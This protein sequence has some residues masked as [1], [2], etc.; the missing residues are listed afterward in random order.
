MMLTS[1]AFLL[2]IVVLQ[3]CEVLPAPAWG[4]LLLLFVPLSIAFRALRLPLLIFCGFL[5]ALLQAH[6]QLYPELSQQW[7]GNDLMVEGVIASIPQNRGRA[8]RFL[9]D[10]DRVSHA[11]GRQDEFPRRIRLSWYG[12]T[13]I[14]HLAQRWKFTVRLKRPRGFKNPG[15]FDY[16]R[17][18]FAQGIRATG[19]VRGGEGAVLLTDR[20]SSRPVDLLRR[21]LADHITQALG[22]ESNRGV[23]TALTIGDRSAM[24]PQ[25]WRLLL[26]TGTNHLLAISGLHIGLVAGLIYFLVLRMWSLAGQLCLKWP[27]PRIAAIAAIGAGC[28]YAMLAGF[29]VPT[30]RAA[31]MLCV[32]MGAVLLNRTKRAVHTLALA[33]MVVLIW[34]SLAVLSA[35]FWLSFAAVAL[36]FY[37]IVDRLSEQRLWWRWGRV[38]WVLAIGLFPLTLILFQRV[39]LVAPI[40]N[41]FAVPW[42]GMLIVPLTLMGSLLATVSTVAGEF[43]LGVASALLDVFWVGLD[44]LADFPMAQ[45]HHLP[46]LWALMPAIPGLILLLAP[47]GWPGRW[48][49]LVLFSPLVLTSP[50]KPAPGDYWV[51]LLDVGQGLSMVI[52]T[53]NHTLVYDAGAR[54]SE[55]FNAGEAVVA[56][57]LRARGVRT[58]DLLVISHG[59]N[60]HIGGADAIMH[61]LKVARV[62]TSVPEQLEH[63]SIDICVAGMRW[64]WDGVD[65]EVLHP[66]EQWQGSKNDQSCVLFLQGAGGSMLITG[67]IESKAEQRLTT[68]YQ[69]RLASDIMLIPHHGSRSSST[70]DFLEQVAPRLALLSVGSHNRFH[71]PAQ[72]VLGRYEALG[73][74]VLDTVNYGAIGV[75]I[76]LGRGLEIRPGF[77]QSDKR[78]WSA[79]SIDIQ[80]PR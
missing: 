47:R 45:W 15:G 69:D 62:L 8:V 42:V 38:Q 9:F 57:Y 29:S 71:L 26:S 22:D 79:G 19:Y 2:G 12:S 3:H 20:V 36:I 55:Y 66:A 50:S 6:G 44:W 67:D 16:E 46:P 33:L 58:V 75:S 27:A 76:S 61:R 11:G 56:P 51:T 13:Q 37:A 54:F 64:H 40:A 53:R 21:T 49:G 70:S 10:L 28:G 65:F 43:V 31:I 41:L 77:R 17:W 32:V 59:D 4:V 23:I 34:D 52:E 60:D 35:G 74:R 63:P 18:L 1:L 7:E 48:L 30:Q 73:A 14:L 80:S 25:Q 5:W 68:V 72:Q 78:Y 24:S 39:S